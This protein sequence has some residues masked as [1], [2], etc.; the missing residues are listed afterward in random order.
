MAKLKT[1]ICP[2]CEKKINRH[3]ANRITIDLPS[4]SKQGAK[5]TLHLTCEQGKK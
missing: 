3:D 2:V 1:S 4:G 5:T